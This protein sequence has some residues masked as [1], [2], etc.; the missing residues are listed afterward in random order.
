MLPRSEVAASTFRNDHVDMRIPL[1]VTT[2]GMERTDDPRSKGFLVIERVHPVGDHLSRSFEQKIKKGAV[3]SKEFTKFLGNG[4]NNV[5]VAAVD[6]LCGDGIGTI[7][8]IGGAAGITETRFTAKG[9]KVKAFAVMTV[10]ESI[11]LFQITTIQH[12]FNFILN[13][14]TNARCGREERGPVILK[15]LLYGELCTHKLSPKLFY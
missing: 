2:E 7:G 10:V 8:L 13:D 9:D 5:P 14:R 11:T 15:Y 4:K 1:E 12:F 3:L 6:Q